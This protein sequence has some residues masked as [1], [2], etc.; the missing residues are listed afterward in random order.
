MKHEG[1]NG[2]TDRKKYLLEFAGSFVIQAPK[3]HANSLN[4]FIRAYQ[5]N[6]LK[7]PFSPLVSS[8]EDIVESI[9]FR[10]LSNESAP[11]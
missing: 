8:V 6:Y 3:L 4:Y 9:F 5:S 2:N 1:R 10:I 11:V 7:M